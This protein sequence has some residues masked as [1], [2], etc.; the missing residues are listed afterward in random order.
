MSVTLSE[1]FS[2]FDRDSGRLR[3]F[4]IFKTFRSDMSQTEPLNF[5]LEIER[6]KSRR[7]ISCLFQDMFDREREALLRIMRQIIIYS[8]YQ[9]VL[10]LFSF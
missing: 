4:T 7:N 1:T 6:L 9:R 5:E 10:V 3:V 8:F 2:R